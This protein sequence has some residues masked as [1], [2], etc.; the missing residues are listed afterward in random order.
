MREDSLPTEF[1]KLT[2]KVNYIQRVSSYEWSSSCPNCGGVPHKHGEP[3]DRFRM[4]TNANGK[5]KVLGWCRRCGHVWFPDSKPIDK[6][7]FERWRK[8]QLETE[9][10]R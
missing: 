1:A 9:R 4:W 2:G 5:N 3:P 6:E 8:E 7:E 10:Q